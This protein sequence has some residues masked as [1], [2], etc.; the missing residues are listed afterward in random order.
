MPVASDDPRCIEV[1]IL[2]ATGGKAQIV[3]FKLS[4]DFSYSYSEK[5]TI[6]S[7][8]T[9]EHFE[10]WQANKTIEIKQKIDALAQAEQDALLASSDWYDK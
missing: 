7:D 9:P 4:N 6:P 1:E 8:W 2:V 5:Y 3:Q 10:A